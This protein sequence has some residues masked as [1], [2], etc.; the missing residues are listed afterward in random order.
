MK[1][2]QREEPELEPEQALPVQQALELVEQ[3]RAQKLQ[4]R[5]EFPHP[6]RLLCDAF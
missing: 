4:Q 5:L 1:V 6:Y 3:H 2:E